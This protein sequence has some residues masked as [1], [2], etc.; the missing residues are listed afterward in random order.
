MSICSN[1]N[2]LIAITG[3]I[4]SG[5]TYVCKLLHE[6]GIDVYDCDAAAKRLMR[7][8]TVLRN[9]I[10]TLVGEEAYSNGILQKRVLAEYLL[11]SDKNREALNNVVHPAVAQD[12]VSSGFSWLE[13]AIL[14]DSGFNTRVQFDYIVCVSAPVE[15]RLNR[16]AKR[17]NITRQKA[18]E[19]I[20]RQLPQQQVEKLSDFVILNDGYAPLEEQVDLLLNNIDK[21][22]HN[23]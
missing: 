3:G 20:E 10:T 13:S 22:K 4:G 1:H 17:D 9:R 23:K 15:I 19:W 5:K 14:F 21:I 11:K 2:P 6:R 18:L 12:F 8:N 16:V 7:E